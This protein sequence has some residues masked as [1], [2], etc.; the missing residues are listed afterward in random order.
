MIS[1]SRT[2]DE[3]ALAVGLVNTWD[4]LASDPEL[5]ADADA[6]RRLLRFYEQDELAERV[7]EHDVRKMRSLRDRLRR[8]FE[9]NSED[10]AVEALNGVL[11][12]SGAVAQLVRAGDR[13]AYRHHAPG[14]SLV[15]TVATIT[16]IALLDVVRTQ[17]W[18]RF[19]RCAAAPCCCVFV[20]RS[21]SRSR[22]Y[23]CD[24]CADRVS[25]AAYRRR[26]RLRG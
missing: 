4:T 16:T 25:Q 13:W 18:G 14:A 23:C 19:G 15:D 17:G 3:A 8:A 10:D 21:R 12:S 1:F 26:A 11:R 22:L 2:R 6:L 7:A 20:D 9:A 5:L 24:L